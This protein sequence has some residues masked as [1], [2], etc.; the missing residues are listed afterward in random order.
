MTNGR[1]RDV[2]GLLLAGGRSRR[3]GT[4]KAWVDLHGQPL[5]QRV[6]ARLAPQ[7]T[8]LAL[9]APSG[10]ARFAALG[11]TIV[12]DTI[13]GHPGPL[14][15]VLA[16]MDHAR[17]LPRPPTHVATAPVDAPFLPH[18][19]VTRLCAAQAR[20]GAA[21]ALARSAGKRHPVCAL[22][23]TW[24]A[25]DLRRRLAGGLR[26]V[27]LYAREKGCVLVDWP[28]EPI[29]PFLNL[30]APADVALARTLPA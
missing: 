17:A 22:W 18:D 27:D 4:D 5:V 28:A 30:N 19:L 24:L 8:V 25:E 15:G 6:A 12:P 14:A 7:V 23:P 11:W 10:D 16:G 1:G 9:N 3:M 21:V 29:D 20:T 2:L 26:R 13:A